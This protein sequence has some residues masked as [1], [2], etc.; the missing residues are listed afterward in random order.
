MRGHAWTGGES[1]PPSIIVPPTSYRLAAAALVRTRCAACE[2]SA[3]LFCQFLPSL[4][5]CRPPC[6]PPLVVRFFTPLL[7][8]GF[9]LALGLYVLDNM[10]ELTPKCS[11]PIHRA[12]LPE[13]RSPPA[14]PLGTY[15]YRSPPAPTCRLGSLGFWSCN[16]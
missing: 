9:V 4:V 3:R 10:F 16:T 8:T 7:P 14:H 6:L 1:T 15:R 12:L 11:P 2:T 5:A 13:G